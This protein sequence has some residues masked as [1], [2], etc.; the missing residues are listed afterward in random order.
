[1]KTADRHLALTIRRGLAAPIR[2]VNSPQIEDEVRLL[3][4]NV[5]DVCSDHS[6]V[7]PP[8]N[9]LR[10]PDDHELVWTSSKS[11]SI[12]G[13]FMFWRFTRPIREVKSSGSGTL[14]SL[15]HWSE[16]KCLDR[17]SIV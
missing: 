5:R 16:R 1:M 2:R 3:L 13:R 7:N 8:F 6:S 12:A 17:K 10:V 11:S 4:R 14:A 9:F 15:S